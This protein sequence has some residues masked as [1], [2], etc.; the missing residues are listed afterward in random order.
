[1]EAAPPVAPGLPLPFGRSHPWHHFGG[2]GSVVP[3]VRS[4]R[5]DRPTWFIHPSRFSR[6]RIRGPAHFGGPALVPQRKGSISSS[7]QPRVFP[8]FDLRRSAGAG[9]RKSRRV[10]ARHIGPGGPVRFPVLSPGRKKESPRREFSPVFFP[11]REFRAL[12]HEA[13]R[14]PVPPQH[15]PALLGGGHLARLI[16]RETGV[17]ETAPAQG[18]QAATCARHFTN[19]H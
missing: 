16:R 6:R 1:M 3:S 14:M 19:G 8:S 9:F 5:Q 2:S 17:L 4:N 11:V 10:E 18:S 15:R 7:D 13:G 12:G